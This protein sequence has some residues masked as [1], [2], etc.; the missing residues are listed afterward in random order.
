MRRSQR[1]RLRDVR[2]IYALL[3][4]I[5][6]VTRAEPGGTAWRAVAL[7]GLVRL[8]NGRV[9]L[10]ADLA[11][12][13]PAGPRSVDPLDVG[14]EDAPGV[15]RRY[16]DYLASG[17]FR[18]DP[19]TIALLG[20]HGGG[21]KLATWRRRDRVDDATWYAAP[22]VAEARRT[23]EVDDFVATTA[24]VAPGALH[25]LVVYRGWG[26]RPFGVRERRIARVF[27]VELL[28]MIRQGIDRPAPPGAGLPPRVR[29]VLGMVTQGLSTKEIARRMGLSTHT[30]NDYM[31]GLYRRT[32]VSSR[33]E[34]LSKVYGE[35][36]EPPGRGVRL[37]EGLV[38]RTAERTGRAP[39]P[40]GQ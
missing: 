10:T 21:L 16:A 22:A 17:E 3:G 38:G 9:G 35:R 37:P 30:V 11:S 8:L 7:R 32:G 20:A 39:S 23:G 25:G 34:L 2:G 15:R 36:R 29:E 13:G 28:R 14:W 33:A 18:D 6:E 26:E 5:G 24:L 19:G 31:K 1:L 12:W 40:P 27:H 4:E